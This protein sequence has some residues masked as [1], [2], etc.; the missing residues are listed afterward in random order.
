MFLDQSYYGNTGRSWLLA[1][2]VLAAT[3]AVLRLVT[4][5]IL[6]RLTAFA[7]K[8]KTDLDD[9]VAALLHKTKFFFLLLLSLYAT[10]FVLT[11]PERA[12]PII[13][14]VAVIAL[15]IQAAVWSSALVSF[16]IA[17]YRK[18]KLAEDPATATTMGAL[19]FIAKLFLWAVV[20]LLILDNLGV[21]IT[22]LIAGLGIGG[23]A[24]ALALQNI[25]GDLFASLSIVLDKPFVLGDF[26]IVGELMGTVEKVGLKTTRVRSLSGEQ[27]VFSNNDL[28]KSRIRNY[29][30]MFER[31]I[32][33]SFGVTYQTSHDQLALIPEMVRQLIESQEEA[34]FDRAHFKEYGDFSLNFEVVYY[35]K[36]PDY[37][38]YMDTQQ[39]INLALY[40]KFQ[41]QGIEFAYPTQTLYLNSETVHMPAQCEKDKRK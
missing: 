21:N 33:F 14:T 25:L 27:L 34:R 5:L 20:L 11:L 40:K 8:T 28:L 22:S 37:N 26:I 23:I 10:T 17:R 19:N 9:L 32:L 7:K 3:V 6:R 15:L 12:E 4:G 16:S 30:R 18:R 2:F 24:V 29:K 31:R 41:E 38:V 39:A 36:K 13:S 35:V 1:L